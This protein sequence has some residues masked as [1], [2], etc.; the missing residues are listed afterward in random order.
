MDQKTS[1][2]IVADIIRF[3]SFARELNE[4]VTR[5]VNQA[6]NLREAGERSLQL[7]EALAA[8]T[9]LGVKADMALREQFASISHL[10]S[11]LVMTIEKQKESVLTLRAAGLVDPKIEKRLMY[12][13]L[14]L[15]ESLQKAVS[16]LQGMSERSAAMVLAGN[17]VERYCALA[18][19][20]I[21]DFSKSAVRFRK[22]ADEELRLYGIKAIKRDLSEKYVS[23]AVSA[24]S[25]EEMGGLSRL[26]DEVREELKIEGDMSASLAQRGSCPAETGDLAPDARLAALRISDL[27]S[28]INSIHRENLEEMAQLTVILSLEIEEYLRIRDI[29]DPDRPGDEAAGEA[30]FALTDLSVLL[31]LSCNAVQNL[32]DM[33][34]YLMELFDSSAKREERAAGISADYL[35][36]WNAVMSD[37]EPMEKQHA[38]IL[39]GLQKNLIIGQ[40]LEKNLV[41]AIDTIS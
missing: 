23:R 25:S 12:R 36:T 3:F 26:V 11:M 17:R 10:C 2:V 19:G 30:H 6:G 22:R 4:S 31:D 5:R 39:D 20:H 7:C 16:L 41:K 21:K 9:D 14:M 37:L 33:N 1:A 18:A 38:D 29:F 27:V 32:I 15:S 24:V 40:V 8:E 13:L 35:A 28:E 34:N